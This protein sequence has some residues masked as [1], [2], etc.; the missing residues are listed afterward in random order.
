[1]PKIVLVIALALVLPTP[2]I[3]LHHSSPRMQGEGKASIESK[4]ARSDNIILLPDKRTSQ[5]CAESDFA[6]YGRPV[7]FSP[8]DGIAYGVSLAPDKPGLVTIWMDNQTQKPQNV[9]ICCNATFVRYIDIYNNAGQRI[10]G[11]IE[12]ANTKPEAAA[13]HSGDPREVASCG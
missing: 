4:V 3:L 6:L 1:M 12:I 2:P 7:M 8:R 11:K 9:F 13:F 10:R 5:V